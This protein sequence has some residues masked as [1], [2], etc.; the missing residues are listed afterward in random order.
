MIQKITELQKLSITK[1]KKKYFDE[2]KRDR[3][4][5]DFISKIIGV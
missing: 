5:E 2:I 4:R 1:Q 3:L